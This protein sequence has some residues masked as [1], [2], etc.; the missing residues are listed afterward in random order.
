MAK[1]ATDLDVSRFSLDAKKDEDVDL[2]RQRHRLLLAFGAALSGAAA[3]LVLLVLVF[4]LSSSGEKTLTTSPLP[5]A[6]SESDAVQA[7]VIQ[8]ISPE[9][10]A[11]VL[12][13]PDVTVERTESSSEVLIDKSTGTVY[14]PDVVDIDVPEAVANRC[15]PSVVSLSVT[16]EGATSNGSGVVLDDAGHILTNDHV[17]LGAQDV[18]VH[19]SSGNFV[20]HP[21]GS[22]PTSDLVVL[23]VDGESHLEPMAVGDS[24]DLHVGQWVMAIGAPFGLEQSV[25]Q[26]IVS[27]LY[28]STVLPSWSGTNVY[29]NLI[30]TDAATNPGSS[31][32]ALVNAKG[33]LVGINSI[34]SSYD[35]SFAGVGFAIPANYAVQVARAIIEGRPVEHACLGVDAQT[36]T[37]EVAAASNLGDTKGALVT[38]V[39][40]GTAAEAAGVVAGDVIVR[41]GETDVDSVEALMAAVRSENV[42]AA[43]DVTVLRAGQEFV[44]QMSLGTDGG[45]GFCVA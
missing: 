32:G 27:S 3:M 33:E 4:G 10:G 5:N 39:Y 37:S 45:N 13:N 20:A 6:V 31:G 38:T 14:V 44:C 28:R 23:K 43:V 24:A 26:G 1:L 29:T 34:I 7:D 35:G 18:E 9:S 8:D 12:S 42:G 16:V 30:Q 15:L 41:V 22:D 11:D 21:V 17:V 25:S 40:Q 36:V 2:P 19:A